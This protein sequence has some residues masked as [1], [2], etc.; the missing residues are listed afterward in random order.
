VAVL[1]PTAG[2]VGEVLPGRAVE[3]PVHGAR[4]HPGRLDD[5][6]HRRRVQALFDIPPL[7]GDVRIARSMRARKRPRLVGRINVQ[8]RGVISR[9]RTTEAFVLVAIDLCCP[10]RDD[11]L[12][13]GLSHLLNMRGFRSKTI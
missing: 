13:H 1:L 4:R 10:A 2:Q 9:S 8:V 5:P 6:I 12:G 7:T 3:T 11:H